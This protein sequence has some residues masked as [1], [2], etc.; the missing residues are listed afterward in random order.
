[1][2][3][4]PEDRGAA[5]REYWE[6]PDTISLRDDN[7]RQLEAEA[8]TRWLDSE[9]VVLDVG[10]GDGINTVAYAQRV[11]RIVGIDYSRQRIRR[12]TRRITDIGLHNVEFQHL[13]VQDLK[14][15]SERFDIAIS[16]RCLINLPT[17]EEQK[18]AIHQIYC[19][20]KPGR[21]YLMLECVEQ[22]RQH[23]NELRG[24]V[25]LEPLPM[26][27]HD[28]FFDEDQLTPLL[29]IFFEIVEVVDFSLYYLITRILNPIM[30]LDLEDPISKR[31]DDAAR[32]LQ[33]QL[34][35]DALSGIGPQRLFVLR[36][37]D[38]TE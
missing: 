23:L 13:S 19:I 14:Q 10:C 3:Q 4:M 37:R 1:M 35:F 21:L 30:G 7:L 12:A 29:R 6:R 9:S 34:H 8:I 17:F 25:G 31:I 22:G 16:Q 24:Q 2:I 5:M 38:R 27:W 33:T 28:L 11:H 15:I 18:D 36:A 32:Q 20:L 26:P